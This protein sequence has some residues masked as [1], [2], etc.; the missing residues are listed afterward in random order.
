MKVK[1]KNIF[2][3]ICKFSLIVVGWLDF[4]FFMLLNYCLEM[5]KEVPEGSESKGLYNKD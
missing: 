1:R 4:Y 5:L 2:T 3:F